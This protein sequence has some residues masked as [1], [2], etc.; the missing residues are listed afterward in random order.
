MNLRPTRRDFVRCGVCSAV[1]A[2]GIVSTVMD[3][4]KMN[5]VAAQTA[6]YR[7][8]VCLFLFGGNDANNLLVPRAG[9]DYTA[10]AAGRGVLT[11]PAASLLPITPARGT[12]DTQK[13]DRTFTDPLSPFTRCDRGP[14]AR[15]LQRYGPIPV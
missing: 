13:D 4:C 3:L 15:R 2:T 6:N 10:Y 8:L 12:F 9:A 5:A 14:V 7:A 11:L 1:G